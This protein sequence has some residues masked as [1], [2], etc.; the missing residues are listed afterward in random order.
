MGSRRGEALGVRVAGPRSICSRASAGTGAPDSRPCR[1]RSGSRP[2]AA[3]SPG[4]TSGRRRRRGWRARPRG[5]RRCRGSSTSSGPRGRGS[6]RGRRSCGSSTRR[7][8]ASTRRAACRTSRGSGP[9]PRRCSRPGSVRRT[10]PCSR[11]GSGTARTHAPLSYQVDHRSTRASRRRTWR[12]ARS[13]RLYKGGGGRLGWRRR[14]ARRAPRPS[15]A[16]DLA[17]LRFGA[18]PDRQ[19][20]PPVAS[21]ESAQS[22]LFSSHCRAAVLDVLGCQ[23]IVSLLRA[24]PP[25][26]RRCA[27]TSSSG[28]VEQRRAAAPAVRV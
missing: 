14:S 3:G 15:R 18:A 2:R 11:T 7:T 9:G 20:R 27:R 13:S 19:R 6:G 21:R 25:S 24:A 12:R 16:L 26:P 10:A 28:V 8:A 17:A 4:S 22:T 23:P 1:P 5:R